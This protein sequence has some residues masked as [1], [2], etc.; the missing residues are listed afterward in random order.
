MKEKN[1][2]TRVRNKKELFYRKKVLFEIKEILDSNDIPF[3]IWGGLLL[4]IKRD[5][6]LISWDWD[7]E[8]GLFEKDLRFNWSTIINLLKKNKF[9]IIRTDILNLKIEFIKYTG[10]ESTVFSFLGWRYDIFSGKY[11]RK[12]LNVPKHFFKPMHRIYFKDQKF[13]CP[14]PVSQFLTYF[15]GDWKKPKR[16][17][18]KDDYLSKK[19]NKRNLWKFYVIIDRFKFIILNYF[20]NKML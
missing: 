12:K 18:I 16:T 17:T 4:G 20:K 2:K 7:I 13:L 14:G 5:N 19:I 3:F 9:K 15:Y 8:I 6:D 1:L 10:M 11:L